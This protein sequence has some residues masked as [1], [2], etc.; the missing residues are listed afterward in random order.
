MPHILPHMTHHHIT[1]YY[2]TLHHLISYNT[3][4]FTAPQS[5]PLQALVKA[6]YNSLGLQTY[7]TSGPTET[8]A[9]T[10]KKGMTAPQVHS[11]HLSM[12]SYL[13]TYVNAHEDTNTHAHIHKH[14]HIHI[15]ASIHM[16]INTHTHTSIYTCIHTHIQ[17]YTHTYIQTYTHKYIHT[18]I[19]TYSHT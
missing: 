12:P 15:H 7:F 6:A 11:Y 2:M 3:S 16:H 19:H 8:K 14:I 10:I 13:C 4:Y 1:S 18:D 9:W 5:I 17:T